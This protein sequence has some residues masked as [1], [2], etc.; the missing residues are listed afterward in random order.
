MV[1]EDLKRSPR[2]LKNLATDGNGQTQ[3]HDS[4]VFSP[5]F[6]SAAAMAGW[7]EEALL[8][9]SLIVEDTPDRDFKHKKRSVFNSKTPPS[10]SRRKRIAQST[11]ESIRVAVLDLDEEDTAK[12]D[13]EKNTKE[14]KLTVNEESKEGGKES[15][16]SSSGAALPCI[17]KLRDEL[18]CA[19]CLEICFEPSTTPCGHSFCKKCL[20]SAADK[21]GKKCPKC[22]QLIGIGRSCT[23][24][25]V[26]WNTIQLLFPQEVKA[27]K[28]AG[29][30]NSRQESKCLSPETAF[31]NNL[32]NGESTTTRGG[33]S[34][35]RS[36]GRAAMVTD[37]GAAVAMRILRE[38]DGVGLLLQTRR[39]RLHLVRPRREIPPATQN[40]DAAL[41]LRLQREEFIQAFRGTQE[42][43]YSSRSSSV[44]SSARENLR[45]MASRAMNLRIRDQRL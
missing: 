28:A 6:K 32:R 10:N 42:Q 12:K 20:R 29:T 19:I 23:V 3:N 21:C 33:V 38:D 15:D 9:A 1:S 36:S 45:A 31:Y 13:S 17:D 27:R 37:Q 4:G 34:T 41:A 14:K 24:N 22:R 44:N 11:S 26:L 25:T 16:V 40:E 39:P 7:D 43:N 18:S 35:R 2:S 8:L 30:I 5:R